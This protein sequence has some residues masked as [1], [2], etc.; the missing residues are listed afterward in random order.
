MYQFYTAEIIKTQSG[1]FEHDIKW[2][3]DEDE[4]KAQLK[5]E[6]KFHEILSRAAVS[7]N[8]EHAAI[9]F[10]SKGNRIMDKCYYHIIETTPEEPENP[11]EPTEEVIGE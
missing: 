9:L 1:D 5:G 3:W 7:D 6:A 2:H 8:A 10:S 11:E 4:Y